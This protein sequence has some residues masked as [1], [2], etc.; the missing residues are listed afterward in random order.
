MFE[1]EIK[2]LDVN[3][4]EAEKKL[5]SMG[6]EFVFNTKQKIYTYDLPT[7]KK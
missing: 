6:A 1:K 3:V 2:I 4:E 5:L 7:M